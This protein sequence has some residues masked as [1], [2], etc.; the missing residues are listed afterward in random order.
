MQ[1]QFICTDAELADFCQQAA[2]A[3]AIAVDTE[4]V[5]TRT[6]YPKLGLIQLY[7]GV[8]LVLVDPLEIHDFAP[9]R[10]LLTDPNTVKVLHSCSEDM[11]TFWHSLG[12]MPS[13]VFDTQFAACV[14]NMGPTL[15]YGAL[16]ELM[17]EVKLDKGESRTDWLARPLSP[18]QCEYAANDVLYLFNLYPQL[19]EKVEALDRVQWVYDEMTQ[20]AA[21]KRAQMPPELAY[22]A[23]KN[24]WQLHGKSLL[25]LQNLAAWRLG[26]ARE[27]DLALNFVVRES[28]LVEVAKRRPSHKGGIFAISGMTPQEARVHGE[29]MLRIVAEANDVPP[30]H[31]PKAVERLTEYPGFKKISAAIRQ[32]CQQV[33]DRLEFPVEILGSK[34]QIQQLL[35]W[36]WF[37]QDELRA[38]GL[39]PD[40]ISSWRAPLL[41]QGI[42]ALLG[43]TLE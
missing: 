34:K 41:K 40:L 30:E 21:K 25:I 2:K 33:A 27:R 38:N 10:N 32:H 13:P 37:E 28:N 14:A 11:E 43:T 31:Y 22:L 35:K 36:H 9:L 7:D 26:L 5:R 42:E 15:G 23:I 17:L 16:V 8:S 24:N 1:Y 20:L 39:K 4:F 6:L 29:A 19:R 12:V 18:K 3:Q